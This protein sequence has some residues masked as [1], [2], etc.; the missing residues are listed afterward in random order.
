MKIGFV[1]EPFDANAGSFGAHGYCLA[2]ELV[3][4]GHKLWGP[5]LPEMPG[6]VSLRNDKWGKLR[7]ARHADLLYIRP[8]NASALERCTWLRLLRPR[9]PVIWEINGTTDEML[10]GYAPD[11]AT[12]HRYRRE[13]RRKRL[14]ARLVDA[15]V[16]VS[17]ELADYAARYYG[18]R[19]CIVAPNG[20]DPATYLPQGGGTFLADL[21]DRFI[22]FWAG[23]A[24]FPWQGVGDMLAA[25]R[26]CEREAPDVLFVLL[27]GGR[28]V[29][30]SWPHGRNTIL[31]H[32]TDRPTV[33]RYL[34]D[35]HCVTVLYRWHGVCDWRRA[36]GSS[37]KLFEAMAARKPVIATA[38][39]QQTEVVRDGVDGLLVPEDTDALV[40]A[41][42]RLRSDPALR[43]RLAAA[44]RERIES[45]YTWR[46][47]VDRIE[48][49]LLELAGRGLPDPT[50][51]Q[52]ASRDG[53]RTI[54]CCRQ[55][56][57]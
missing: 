41:I 40:R 4:R 47:T 55:I 54:P 21:N 56:S 29:R 8:G 15:A 19:R 53:W 20:G 24:G 26:R 31:L 7:M 10:G 36:H 50:S 5:G 38:L 48:P 34:A 33:R 22:V 32:G 9:C 2:T 28:D 27:L 30:T 16:C 12:L 23:D 3:R 46:H 39:G 35:A 49:L 43:E 52:A 51:R 57:A 37:L 18:I 11:D 1:Y 14:L 42:L 25:A 17:S 44:A 13:I 45:A 6:C